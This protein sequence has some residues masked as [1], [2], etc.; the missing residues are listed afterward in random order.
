MQ[1]GDDPSEERNGSDLPF[2]LP[3]GSLEHLF[4][5]RVPGVSIGLAKL[6]ERGHWWVGGRMQKFP[7]SVSEP[8]LAE[9][10]P[11]GLHLLAATPPWPA[12]CPVAQSQLAEFTSETDHPPNQ[13]LFRN[14][15]FLC[16]FLLL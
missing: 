12:P 14:T 13:K 4:P 3:L 7:A 9:H 2:L 11:P 15:S 6:A 1:A 8:N 16:L 10:L 5:L